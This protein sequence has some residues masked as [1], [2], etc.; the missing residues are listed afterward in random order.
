[1]D[2]LESLMLLQATTNLIMEMAVIEEENTSRRRWWVHPINQK[3][4]NS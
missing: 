4:K 2:Q 1:M 3:Q